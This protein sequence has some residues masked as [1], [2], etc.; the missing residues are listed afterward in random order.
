MVNSMQQLAPRTLSTS[1]LSDCESQ[2]MVFD[3]LQKLCTL[4]PDLFKSAEIIFKGDK[5]LF[6]KLP[7]FIAQFLGQRPR[8]DKVSLQNFLDFCQ[9]SSSCHF[10]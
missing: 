8:P 3:Y 10:I 2:Q 7:L 1:T 6:E 4:L 5:E 9:I